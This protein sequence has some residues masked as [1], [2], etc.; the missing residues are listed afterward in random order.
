MNPAD[1]SPSA[2]SLAPAARRSLPSSVQHPNMLLTAGRAAVSA[3]EDWL[4]QSH[5]AQSADHKH[6][7]NHRNRLASLNRLP[8]FAQTFFFTRRAAH[9]TRRL[10]PCPMIS[11]RCK[12]TRWSRDRLAMSS[13][14]VCAVSHV[15]HRTRREQ[16]QKAIA[17]V[18]DALVIREMCYRYCS[19]VRFVLRTA[20]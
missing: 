6:S 11:P 15:Q 4:L 14:V 10:P 9:A 19:L 18:G 5:A 3:A 8:C 16:M 1:P 12:A 17:A 7:A 20:M 13:T 2:S